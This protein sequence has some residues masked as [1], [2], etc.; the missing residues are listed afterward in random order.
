MLVD[1]SSTPSRASPLHFAPRERWRRRGAGR[2]AGAEGEPV[3]ALRRGEPEGLEHLMAEHEVRARRVAY[4]ITGDVTTA[5]DV[6]AEAF[7]K[8]YRA[9]GRFEAGRPFGPWLLTIL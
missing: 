1:G 7:L 5:D 8:A 4:A 2:R 9:I 3:E 6:V